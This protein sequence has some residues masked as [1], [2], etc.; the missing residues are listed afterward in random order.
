MSLTYRPKRH[1]PGRMWGDAE[2]W[3]TENERR[4]SGT[5]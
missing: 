5:G 3:H 4:E 1:N 2:A